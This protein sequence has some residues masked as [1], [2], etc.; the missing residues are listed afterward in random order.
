MVILLDTNIVS[1]LR[2]PERADPALAAWAASVSLDAAWLS[3]ATILELERGILLLERRDPRQGGEIRRWFEVDLLPRYADRILPI[4]AAV[5]RRCAALHIPDPRPFYDALIA[6]TAL[7]HGLT[8]V[9]RD[10][11]DFAPMGL[12][13][14]NPWEIG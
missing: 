3:A 4:D 12:P 11:A 14:L 10:T 1:G 9:T 8:L 7:V 5:A 6:A 13:L 2:R